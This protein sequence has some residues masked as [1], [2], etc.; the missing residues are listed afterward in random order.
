MTDR[1]TSTSPSSP[2]ISFTTSS[3]VLRGTMMPGMPL[4]PF[5]QRHLGLG[6]AVAVG[7]HGAQQRARRHLM[8]IDAVQVIAGLFGRDGKAGFLDQALE[9]GGGERKCI[10]QFA[11]GEIGE[12]L[13]RQ[14]LQGKA[15]ACRR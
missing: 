11:A 4:A 10:G 1:A 12:I 14:G 3:T 7:C 6:Q 5:G 9:V 2:S 15:R 8:Q 13:G